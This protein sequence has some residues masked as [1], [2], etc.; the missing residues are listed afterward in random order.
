MTVSQG[1][2]C[3]DKAHRLILMTAA[4]DGQVVLSDCRLGLVMV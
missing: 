3:I 1:A 4:M 2:L